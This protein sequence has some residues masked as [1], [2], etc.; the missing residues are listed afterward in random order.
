[1]M[2]PNVF[3]LF[4]P[5][6]KEMISLKAFR[7]LRHFLEDIDPID[8]ADN[9]QALSPEEQAIIFRLLPRK[10]ESQLFE[11]L[12]VSEQQKILEQMTDSNLQ[13]L[14]TGLDPS[15]T[16]ELVRE[17]PPKFV[18]RFTQILKKADS[19][20]TEEQIN[21][22]E[23]TVGSLMRKRFLRI[24]AHWSAQEAL[25]YIR[26][27]T[28]LRH[29]DDIYVDIIYV[30]DSLD[31]LAG[32]VPLKKIIVAPREMKIEALIEKNIH[33]LAPEMDQEEAAN[34]FRKY[35]LISSPIVDSS[36]RMVGILLVRNILKVI[37]QETEE[38]FAKMA[39]T[40]AGLLSQSVFFM[41]KV[42]FPWLITTCLGYFAVGWVVQHF[43]GTLAKVIGLT[44]F[45]PLIAAMGGNVGAQTATA[46]VRGLATGE[47]KSLGKKEVI[48]KE[49]MVGIFL[50]LLY[51]LGAALVAHLVYGARFGWK[52][53]W[54]VGIGMFAAMSSAAM[55]GS[56]EPFIFEKLKIDPATAT[57]PLITFCADFVSTLTYLTVA[58]VLFVL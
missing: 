36:G 57:G 14:L 55:M 44:S 32:Q 47:I 8:L 52:F 46:V 2:K 12:E 18:N 17:L 15:E 5:E 7:S 28:K 19:G 13:S 45:M 56:F 53:S 20:F 26:A 16:S 42:R 41:T 54:V 33:Q 3:P 49:I 35:K 1:M 30:L 22:P 6:I 24:H 43:E 9:W 37:E 4:L 58:T 25:E 38:D 34:L 31:H 50:G 48:V 11:E 39:G 29:I 27:N 23:K 10:L 40:Q 51:G 21:Y